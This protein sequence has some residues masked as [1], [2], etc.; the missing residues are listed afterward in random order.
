M[1]NSMKQNVL[2]KGKTWVLTSDVREKAFS[3]AGETC[4]IIGN[5]DILGWVL[6]IDDKAGD[7]QA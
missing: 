6:P 4:I 5:M 3:F 2:F 1:N 7:E